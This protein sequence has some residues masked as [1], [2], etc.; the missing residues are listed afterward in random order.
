MFR[1]AARWLVEQKNYHIN[2]MIGGIIKTDPLVPASLVPSRLP[3]LGGHELAFRVVVSAR[4]I[5]DWAL[6]TFAQTRRAPWHVPAPVHSGMLA[7][8]CLVGSCVAQTGCAIKLETPVMSRGEF[9]ELPMRRDAIRE[10]RTRCDQSASALTC[11]AL[12]LLLGRLLGRRRWRVRA[13]A[14]RDHDLA[15]MTD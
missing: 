3:L 5:G 13:R 2:R 4:A 14:G 9:W 7:L 11:P 1:V 10:T 15:Q 12:L 6:A 8:W